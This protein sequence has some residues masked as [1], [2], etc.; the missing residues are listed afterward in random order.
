M[1]EGSITL[2]LL[3][4][5]TLGGLA[6]GGGAGWWL[7]GKARDAELST[8]TGELDAELAVERQK[9]AELERRLATCE[10]QV[11][12]NA[13]KAS[14]AGTTDALTAALAPYMLQQGVEASLIQAL[15]QDRYSVEL[16]KVASPR[17]LAAETA[18]TRCALLVQAKD[19]SVLGCGKEVVAEWVAAMHEDTR[20]AEL[21]ETVERLHAAC[22]DA[23]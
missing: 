7:T 12:A 9:G 21:T 17:L 19:S 13:L 22:P 23:N 20:V 2:G 10:A 6:V 1:R 14:A 16:V 11:T 18:M 4:G 5:F 15:S 8:I 3:I